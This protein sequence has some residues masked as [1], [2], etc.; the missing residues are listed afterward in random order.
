MKFKE[1]LK[2]TGLPVLFASL[3]CLSPLVLVIFG[4]S[5][6]A[7][8]GSLSDVLY[9]D[10]K[11]VFR[12]VGFVLLTIS[13][14]YYFRKQKGICTIDQVKKHRREIINKSLLFL[15]IG[16]LG[17]LFFLYIVVHYAGVFYDVWED[18]QY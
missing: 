12:L 13:I 4:L 6:V 5:T 8:A 9:G 17:Y 3:C 11:W 15:I 2:V 1:L 10:Y 7:F 16:V 14:V 18:Y